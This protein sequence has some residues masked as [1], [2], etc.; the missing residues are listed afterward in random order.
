MKRTGAFTLIDSIRA[1][2]MLVT[3]RG[4]L[5]KLKLNLAVEE[6]REKKREGARLH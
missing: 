6:W 1:I 5:K 2:K 3:V 4:I